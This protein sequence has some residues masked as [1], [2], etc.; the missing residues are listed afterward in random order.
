[1]NIE[2]IRK[3]APY[4]AE[5]YIMQNE[6]VLYYVKNDCGIWKVWFS[7][8]SISGWGCADQKTIQDNIDQLKPLSS[9]QK[10]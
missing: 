8:D 9:I 2:E 7:Y 6:K 3:K 10:R 4:D 1:M 5:F